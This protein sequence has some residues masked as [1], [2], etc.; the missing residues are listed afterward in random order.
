MRHILALLFLLPTLAYGAPPAALGNFSI[1]IASQGVVVYN[2]TNNRFEIPALSNITLTGTTSLTLTAGAGGGG[3]TVTN[4]SA[5][6]L[7]PLFTTSEATT[8]TTPALTFTLSTA[9]A[10][11]FFG[12]TTGSSATPVFNTFGTGVDTWLA[13]P[14]S[15][16]LRTAVTDEQ[17]TGSLVFSNSPLIV[18][19]GVAQSANTSTDSAIYG[20][21]FTDTSPVGNFLWFQ[22]SG[23]TTD[24][25]RVDVTGTLT[26]GIIPAARVTGLPTFPS[27]TIIGTTDTQTLTNKRIDPR[28]T[29]SSTSNTTPTPDVSTTDEYIATA[30][31]VNMVFG[32]PTGTPVQ[33]TKL[34]I[35]I[36]DSGSARTLGWNATYVPI[37]V[38]LPTTTVA[39]KLIYVGCIYNSTVPQWDVVAVASEQ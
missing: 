28:T 16:N 37:G 17:G 6:D 14:T 34:I 25:F 27:G 33:G 32:A 11:T 15:A 39:N 21:R 9:A 22:N 7:A 5:G 29:T 8:T 2:S 1:N 24:L 3:G 13:T 19:L 26:A 23:G 35:R 18:N 12:N 38:T 20:V 36:K 10:H 30:M 4:F 31:T